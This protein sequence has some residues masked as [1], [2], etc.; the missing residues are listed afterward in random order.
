MHI[1]IFIAY[2]IFVE[3]NG[4]NSLL[5]CNFPMI[6][7]VRWLAGCS[8]C[9][10]FPKFALP[11]YYRSTYKLLNAL[12]CDFSRVGGIIYNKIIY[13]HIYICTYIMYMYDIH[14]Y[15]S[16]YS[17]PIWS[18]SHKKNTMIPLLTPTAT[19]SVQENC[20]VF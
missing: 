16:Q 6:P 12:F 14:I 5:K 13:I 11:C 3:K 9:H 20:V 4:L 7:H 17:S 18:Q 10:N 15:S 8:A 1:Y 2:I 19:Q